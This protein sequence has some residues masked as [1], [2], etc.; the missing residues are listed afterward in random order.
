MG[1]GGLIYISQS[2][3]DEFE[4]AN[5]SISFRGDAID[6]ELVLGVIESVKE[7]AEELGIPSSQRIS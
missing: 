5:Q 7:L 1:E 4:Y 2:C 6:E 3:S